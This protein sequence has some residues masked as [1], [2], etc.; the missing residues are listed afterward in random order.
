ML[1]FAPSEMIFRENLV[2]FQRHRRFQGQ[3]KKISNSTLKKKNCFTEHTLVLLILIPK[4]VL[5]GAPKENYDLTKIAR[6]CG[7][8]S[9]HLTGEG[10]TTST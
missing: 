2:V 9:T 4:P 10:L 7:Y 8:Y 5:W 3:K 6:R 1:K